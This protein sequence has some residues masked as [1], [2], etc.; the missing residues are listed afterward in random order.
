MLRDNQ[1]GKLRRCGQDEFHFKARTLYPNAHVP[2]SQVRLNNI[3]HVS[4]VMP[5]RTREPYHCTRLT[6]E[7]HESRERNELQIWLC[8]ILQHSELDVI[9]FCESWRKLPTLLLLFD[10]S[11]DFLDNGR[12][13][14]RVSKLKRQ[15]AEASDPVA[16]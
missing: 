5:A 1:D 4:I 14:G 16:M 15:V 12:G 6:L 8:T 10:V 9:L 13:F 11:T 3:S 7:G 2:Y